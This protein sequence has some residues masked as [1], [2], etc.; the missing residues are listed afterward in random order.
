MQLGE[1]FFLALDC[2]ATQAAYD[3]KRMRYDFGSAL[4]MSQEDWVRA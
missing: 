3:G 2:G 1:D 4:Q